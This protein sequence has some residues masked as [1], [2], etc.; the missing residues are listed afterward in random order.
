MNP[1]PP[2]VKSLVLLIINGNM[3]NTSRFST[4]KLFFSNTGIKSP[5]AP[6]W[7]DVW[8]T[9]E[10]GTYLFNSSLL[11]ENPPVAI[12]TALEFIS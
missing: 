3:F 4:L 11:A 6:I 12:I 10:P 1:S 7:L 8:K 2:P 9:S 5:V